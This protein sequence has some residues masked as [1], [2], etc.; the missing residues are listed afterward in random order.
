MVSTIRARQQPEQEQNLLSIL[1]G[2]PSLALDENILN[3]TE[4]ERVFSVE[5]RRP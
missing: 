1:C 5:G 4:K 2:D 3:V